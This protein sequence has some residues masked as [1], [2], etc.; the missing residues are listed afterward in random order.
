MKIEHLQDAE[1]S[2]DDEVKDPKMGAKKVPV[3]AN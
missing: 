1:P 2:K 3:P